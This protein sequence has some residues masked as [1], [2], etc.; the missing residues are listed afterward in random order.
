[1]N[2]NEIGGA[3]TKPGNAV[4]AQP[5]VHK[6]QRL[7]SVWLVPLVALAIGGWLIV[8]TLNE[9]GPTIEI[10]F[11][12][13]EGLEV[14]KTKIKLRD[15]SVGLVSDI[16]LGDEPS[17]VLVEAEIVKDAAR[18][19]KKDSSFWIVRPRIEGATVSGLGTLVSGAYIAMSPGDS[20]ADAISFIGLDKP[21]VISQDEKGKTFILEAERRGSLTSGSPVY[22]RDLRVGE[23][24]SVELADNNQRMDI[25]V[26]IRDPYDLSVLSTTRFWNASGIDFSVSAD[27]VDV[28]VASLETL[29]SGG[30]AF[31]T[32]DVDGRVPPENARFRLYSSRNQ[33]DEFGFTEKIR[34]VMYFDNSV[35]GLTINAPVEFRGIKVGTV[36][37]I[38]A[39]FDRESK[40]V[41]IPVI[42]EIEPQRIDRL[43]QKTEQEEISRRNIDALVDLGLRAQL[44][45]GSLLTGKLFVSLDFHPEVVARFVTQHPTLPELPTIPTVF[46]KFEESA[47]A[48]LNKLQKLPVEELSKNLIAISADL[49]TILS[50]PAIK[51]TLNSSAASIERLNLTIDKFD[52]RVIPKL[53][54]VLQD[55]DSSS[56]MHN[57]I[58]LTLEEM[59]SATAAIRALADELERAPESLLRGKQ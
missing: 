22:L 12:S 14:G 15:V 10:Q 27:G 9:R 58:M 47:T 16:R 40:E 48:I 57:Q 13:A 17:H 38:N 2:K 55:Y 36:I 39:E 4:P 35:R 43:F 25:A 37:R 52:Q 30:I 3:D 49:K 20:G 26:F 7:S 24:T 5:K 53:E 6:K 42:V 56:A 45:T 23:V 21:P 44:Q 32:L 8:H 54:R 18:F 50:D 11:D 41:R 51:Q 31:E 34:Y 46:G 28:Q 59:Q 29:V 1:M 19:V 33:I